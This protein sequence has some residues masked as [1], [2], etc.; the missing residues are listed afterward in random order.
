MN[1]N[2][3]TLFGYSNKEEYLRAIFALKKASP[4]PTSTRFHFDSRVL[5]EPLVPS[6]APDVDEDTD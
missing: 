5:K 1:A 6:F 2:P 4:V 3:K